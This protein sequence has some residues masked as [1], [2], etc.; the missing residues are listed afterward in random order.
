M[1]ATVRLPGW[2]T[3]TNILPSPP[4]SSSDSNQHKRELDY[5]IEEEDDQEEEVGE[6]EKTGKMIATVT[7]NQVF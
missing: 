4:S 2:T 7:R 3:H 1:E 5:G 6:M